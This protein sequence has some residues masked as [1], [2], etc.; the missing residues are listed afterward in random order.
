MDGLFALTILFA[1]GTGVVPI[2]KQFDN[3]ETCRATKQEMLDNFEKRF[4]AKKYSAEYAPLV[5]VDCSR[6]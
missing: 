4:P 2:E 3:L 1:F 6:F 5:L